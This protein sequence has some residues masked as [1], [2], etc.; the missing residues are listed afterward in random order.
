LYLAYTGTASAYGAASS[1][2]VFL[3]W[4]Y[5]SA[6]AFYFGAELIQARRTAP[7]HPSGVGAR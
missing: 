7:A 3:I 1:L 4:V 6:Q 5:Y 2:V